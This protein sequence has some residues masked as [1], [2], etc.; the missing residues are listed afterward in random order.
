M[1]G[2]HNVETRYESVI[3]IRKVPFQSTTDEVTEVFSLYGF[4]Y[5]FKRFIPDK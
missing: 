5:H 3:K 4:Y 1:D 2:S